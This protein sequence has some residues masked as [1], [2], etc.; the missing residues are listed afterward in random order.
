MIGPPIEPEYWPSASGMSTGLI[1]VS[2]DGVTQ[3]E[4]DGAQKPL[5]ENV[6]A[7]MLPGRLMN[8]ASPCRLFV[9]DLVTMLSAGPAVQ[10]YS[11][12]KAFDS[13]VT[14]CTAPTGTVVIIVWRPHASSSF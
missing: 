9:P 1:A 11:D 3:L 6:F 10:P 12:E 13:T 7:C 5:V 2:V 14:S 4:T 8:T